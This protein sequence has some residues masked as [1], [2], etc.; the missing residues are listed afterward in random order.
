MVVFLNVSHMDCN[1]IE[2]YFTWQKCVLPLRYT[3]IFKR[4][5]LNDM[6]SLRFTTFLTDPIICAAYVVNFYP[7]NIMSNMLEITGIHPHITL[8]EEINI[9]KSISEGLNVSLRK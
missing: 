3:M 5:N 2:I 7:W 4:E 6:I 1:Q 9:L 8:L